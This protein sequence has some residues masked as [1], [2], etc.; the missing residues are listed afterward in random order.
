LLEELNKHSRRGEANQ[1]LAPAESHSLLVVGEKREKWSCRVQGPGLPAPVRRGI[2]RVF[3]RKQEIKRHILIASFSLPSD[4]P[5]MGPLSETYTE[6]KRQTGWEHHLP[7]SSLT[8][9]NRSWRNTGTESESKQ[10]NHCH[11]TTCAPQPP[12]SPTA[13]PHE[14]LYRSRLPIPFSQREAT[15]PAL[16]RCYFLLSFS[17]LT[18]CNI[19]T[20]S[21]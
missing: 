7:T 4:L 21:K 17:H 13:V 6:D 5:S 3:H 2:F 18:F 16:G 10:T 12:F 11:R 9:L 8:A 20:K 14:P 15:N 1:T 19:N